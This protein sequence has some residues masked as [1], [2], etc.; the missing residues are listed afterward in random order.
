VIASTW[1][2]DKQTRMVLVVGR[3]ASL[4]AMISNLW[5]DNAPVFGATYRQSLRGA[6]SMTHIVFGGA[7]C[8]IPKLLVGLTTILSFHAA[9]AQET[10]GLQQAKYDKPDPIFRNGFENVT[11]PLAASVSQ[12]GQKTPLAK[13][14][15][16]GPPITTVMPPALGV[17]PTLTIISPVMG[18][19]ISTDFV[20][21]E[22]TFSG[23]A[24]TGIS[25]NDLPV[26]TF[27]NR[28]VSAPIRLN[29]GVAN[30]EV[31]VKTLDGLQATQT[32]TLTIA[33]PP[34]NNVRVNVSPSAGFAPYTARLNVSVE[35]NVQVQQVAVDFNGDGA[36]DYTGAISSIPVY[37]FI[38]AGIYETRVR[39]TEPNANVI[40]R[41]VK[42]AA[43]SLPET[44]ASA[45]AVYAHLRARLRAND[46][47]GA[48]KAF[49]TAAAFDIAPL[50]TSLGPNRVTF[51][52][53]LGPLPTGCFPSIRRKWS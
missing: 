14:T 23:P 28:F 30:I 22:G 13:G 48:L 32:R 2:E 4:R 38:S 16:L 17:L 41:T 15:G 50:I 1:H 44:R 53:R 45:C 21:F 29:V 9:I 51:A 52:D 20:Q 49:T 34:S 12:A 19:T 18:A 46:S 3:A 35:G 8:N 42:V 7:R 11:V 37:R 24:N 36:D 26:Y 40:T 31:K 43:V 6:T 39:V 25:V 47:A 5:F 27:G 10:C 33:A